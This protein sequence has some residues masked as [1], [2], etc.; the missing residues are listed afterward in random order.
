MS[1]RF[2]ALADL[3][4]A[5][6]WAVATPLLLLPISLTIDAPDVHGGYDLH[7]RQAGAFAAVA[8]V[9]GAS[10]PVLAHIERLALRHPRFAR[11]TRALPW[12]LPACLVGAL[13]GG[14]GVGLADAVA[15]VSGFAPDGIGGAL[16]RWGPSIPTRALVLLA[17]VILWFQVGDTKQLRRGLGAGALVVVLVAT[18]RLLAFRGVLAPRME[19]VDWLVAGGAGLVAASFA[20]WRG[21][22]PP[23][24]RLTLFDA[25]LTEGLERMLLLGAAFVA[26]CVGLLGA[27]AGG[28]A[29]AAAAGTTPSPPLGD[30]PFGLPIPVAI[31]L[32][33]FG[34]RAALQ[35]TRPEAARQALDE[36]A[37]VGAAL[38]LG[39]GLGVPLAGESAEV[40]AWGVPILLALGL[41][42]VAAVRP[43]P[44]APRWLSA[45]LP[46]LG[47]AVGA[48][49][50]LTVAET[51]LAVLW[52]APIPV[53]PVAL[54]GVLVGGGLGLLLRSRPLLGPVPDARRALQLVSLVI[55]PIVLV[56][57]GI[58][59]GVARAGTT[60]AVLLAAGGLASGRVKLVVCVWGLFY[61]CFGL[62]AL[63][64][65]GPSAARCASDLQGSEAIP[66][67]LRHE[68]SGDYLSAKP[69]DVLP[70]PLASAVVASFKR[71]DGRGGFLELIDLNDPT[72]RVRHNTLR[73]D[74]DGAFWPERLELDPRTGR[75]WVQL[76]GFGAYAMW[77][78]AV[79]RT[80]P[81]DALTVAV[82][83]RLPLDFEPGNPAIDVV[84]HRM[85]LTYVP[86]RDS[87]NPL[88]EAF[89]LRS[90]ESVAR[91]H[92]ES[93]DSLVMSD[94]VAHDTGSGRY[95]AASLYS[96]ARFALSELDGDDLAEVGRREVFHPSVGLAA[97]S[98]FG[99][100]WVTN[101]AAGTVDVYAP[102]TLEHLQTVRSGAF[103][104]DMVLDR[105][106]GLLHVGA[107]SGGEVWTYALEP[108][109]PQLHLLRRTPVGSL[110]RGIGID[111]GTGTVYA[112]SAC[113]IFAIPTPSR[114]GD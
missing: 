94:F 70:L 98:S 104:R 8:F 91:T 74:G 110:L 56:Y 26:S 64:K 42:V 39:R 49:L 7:L 85:V 58:S 37:W 73:P 47:L 106:R 32:V 69:Y 40:F 48:P 92:K 11:V 93:P 23:E 5:V 55:S 31:L 96:A 54:A 38:V 21:R 89:D 36:L 14:V 4:R 52:P 53:V 67:L 57:L 25:R 79:R 75:V 66:L 87:T 90:L 9:A 71:I 27:R 24:S 113:G 100:V 1:G 65:E 109:R 50:G 80:L 72:R 35:S 60:I 43:R 28:Q 16:D 46:V 108:K 88:A 6:R 34:V 84:R 61:A 112:A 51:V 63:F 12:L 22:G 103:P 33:L 2:I 102:H 17:C 99:G 41:R 62:V 105:G 29:L 83:R 20:L 3:A 19:Q 114:A 44:S 45:G 76:L 68:E 30:L 107:Y 111:E 78:L 86:N 15:S 13:L 101:V 95:Y 10:M 18:S 97:D 81:T 59:W 82:T 77:D